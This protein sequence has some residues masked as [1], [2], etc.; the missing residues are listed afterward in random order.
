[1]IALKVSDGSEVWRWAEDAP[2]QGGSSLVGKIDGRQQLVVKAKQMIAGLD[3][4]TGEELW[5]IPYKVTMDNTLGTPLVV[6]NLVMTSDPYKGVS[7]WHVHSRGDSW[8]V[9][10]AWSNS[11]VYTATSSPVMVA[12]Q[13]VGFGYTRKGELFGI[14]SNSGELLWRGEPRWGDHAS[15]LS[16][17]DEVLV[18]REDGTLVLVK[19]SSQGYEIVRQ[20]RVGESL[21]WAHPAIVGDR[22]LIRDGG[23]L[24]AYQ[25]GETPR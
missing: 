2:S 10:Q 14:D 5:R 3:A 12:G 24:V 8:T 23:R 6:G 16:W 22:L 19:V 18:F 7:A 20:Y 15:L 13:L 25:L 1:M 9:K 11:R 21:M 4:R 17:G